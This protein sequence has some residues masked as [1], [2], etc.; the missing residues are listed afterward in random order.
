MRVYGSLC[1]FIG[2]YASLWVLIC[3]LM[4]PV[5]IMVPCNCTIF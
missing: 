1:F 5:C 3:I 4:G 2:P